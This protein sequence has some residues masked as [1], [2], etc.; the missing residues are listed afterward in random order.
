VR[1][2]LPMSVLVIDVPEIISGMPGCV[3]LT[4]SE[5][6]GYGFVLSTPEREHETVYVVRSVNDIPPN[7][8]YGW[9]AL[10]DFRDLLRWSARFGAAVGRAPMPKTAP[11]IKGFYWDLSLPGPRWHFSAFATWR[12]GHHET[13][14]E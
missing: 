8:P 13:D 14:T 4:F 10:T 2:A 11:P 7:M 1:L 6:A 12:I 5:E 3:A 9:L